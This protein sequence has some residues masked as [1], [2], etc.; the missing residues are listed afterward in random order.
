MQKGMSIKD[1]SES[2]GLTETAL[3]ADETIKKPSNGKDNKNLNL[4]EGIL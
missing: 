1:M 4:L 3:T 2:C